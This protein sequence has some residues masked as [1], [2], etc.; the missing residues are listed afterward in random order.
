MPGNPD[1]TSGFGNAEI[2]LA[3]C[4]A[5]AGLFAEVPAMSQRGMILFSVLAGGVSFVYV[6]RRA[7]RQVAG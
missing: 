1:D 4:P 7:R 6:R 3:A 5:Q 2:Y